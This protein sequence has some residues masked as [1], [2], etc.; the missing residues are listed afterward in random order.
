VV[1]VE[2]NFHQHLVTL[3]VL[4]VVAVEALVLEEQAHLD[5]VI[6]VVMALM[7]DNTVVEAVVELLL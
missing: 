3:E 1:E 7:V 4:V 6:L 5:K 2:V